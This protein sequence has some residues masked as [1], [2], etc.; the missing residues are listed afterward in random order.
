MSLSKFPEQ[1]DLFE[2]KINATSQDDENGD[3][4]MAED[5]NELQDAIVA[6]EKTLG[7]NPQGAYRTLG[8][9]LST[10]GVTAMRVP[11]VL[12]Y[13]GKAS[14]INGATSIKDAVDDFIRYDH[15]VLGNGAEDP[16]NLFHEITK[17]IMDNV[18]ES[19]SVNFYGYID[20]GV[21]TANLTLSQIQVKINQW[22][23]MGVIGIFCDKF[24]FENQVGRARQNLILDSIHQYGLVAMVGGDNPDQLFSDTMDPTYNPNWTAPNIVEGDIYYY[25]KFVL[26]TT[27]SNAYLNVGTMLSKIEKLH[28]YRERLGIKI[29]ATS[30]IST[31]TLQSAAQGYYDYAHA[32]AMLASFDGFGAVT[33]DNSSLTNAANSYQSL[34]LVG[35]WYSK[36]PEIYYNNDYSILSRNTAFGKITIG[37]TSHNYTIEGLTVPTTYLLPVANSVDATFLK[38]ASIEDIKIKN[39]NGARLIQAINNSTEYISIDR[40]AGLTDQQGNI[41]EGLLQANILQALNAQIGSLNAAQAAIGILTAGEIVTGKLS[42][43]RISASVVAAV[44]LYAATM[45]VGDATIN[46]AAIG[47]L[48]ANHIKAA[49]IEAIN[50]SAENISA[51]KLSATVIEAV[52]ISAKDIAADRMRANVVSAINLYADQMTANSAKIN[53]ATIGELTADHIKA[54]VIEAINLS[55]DNAVINAARI[56]DLTADHIKAVVVEA[57]N[58]NATNA[59]ID[60]AKIGDL[61][62]DNMIANVIE[63]INLSVQTATIDGARIRDLNA[64]YITAG[65]VKAD[66]MTA[67]VVDAIN[68]KAGVITSGAAII[69]A[70]AIGTLNA[71]HMQAAVISAINAS[72]ESVTINASRIGVL[73]ADNIKAGSISA[74]KIAANAVTAEKILAGAVEA[75]KIAANAVTAEKILAGA[76]IADKIATGAIEADKIAADAVTADKIKAGAIETEHLGA[77]VVTA[78][79]IKAGTITGT[80]I[81]ADSISTRE[82]AVDAVEAENIKAGVITGDKIVADTITTRELA[83]SSVEAENIKAGAVTADAL[84]ANSVIAGKIAANAISADLIKGVVVEAVNLSASFIQGTRIQARTIDA[85]R[86][87]AQSITATEIAAGTI[88]ATNI[89]ANAITA[90]KIQAGTITSEHITTGGLDAEIISVYNPTTGEVLIGGGYLRVDGLDVGVVQ[91]DNLLVNGLFL[92]ASS[93]YGLWR[94]N[95][96]GEVILGAQSEAVGGHQIWKIDTATGAKLSAVAVPGKKPFG[97]AYDANE[98]YAYV[99]VQGDNTIVQLDTVNNVITTNSLS[100]TTAPGKIVYTG[101]GLTDHKHFF[102]MGTDPDDVNIPDPLI[103]VDA[104]PS[105]INS[106]LYVHHVI[107]LGNNPYDMALDTDHTVYV[108]MANQ[109]DIL[110]LSMHEYNSMNWKVI[111]RIPIS[112]YGTDNYHGGLTG[113]FGLNFVVGGNASESYV[114]ASA[115]ASG[116]VHNHGGYGPPEGAMKTYEPRG[117]ALSTDPSTLYV[118]DNK[119]NQLVI[120]DKHGKAYYNP[121]TGTREQGNLGEWGTPLPGL[122]PGQGSGTDT[123]SGGGHEGHTMSMQSEDT[124]SMMTLPTPAGPLPPEAMDPTP[125]ISG[126]R[127]YTNTNGETPYVRYRIDIGDS[128]EFVVT[129]GGKIFVTLSGSNQ[130]AIMDE[131]EIIAKIEADR[132]YY[133]NEFMPFPEAPMFNV[134]Y[135]NVGSK[136]M[137]MTLDATN[138]KLYVALTAQNQIAVL[139]TATEV[140][141]QTIQAGANPRGMALTEDGST[142]LVANYGGSGTLSFV[143]GQGPYI[144]DAYIGLEGQIN[145]HG[146]HGWMP[147]RSDWTHDANGNVKSS[148]TIEFRINEPFLNEGGYVRMSAQG[149]D[150][151]WGKIEQDIINVINYS[152][153]TNPA[154]T[155]F[156]FHNGSAQI[157]IANGSSPNFFTKFEIDEFVPKF[158]IFDIRQTTPF[159]PVEDGVNEEYSGLEYSVITNRAKGA[160]ITSSVAPTTGSLSSIVDDIEPA[161]NM[162]ELHEHM[163]SMHTYGETVVFPSGLQSVRI[164][165][166]DVY[167]V[168]KIVVQ[169]DFHQKTIFNGTKTEVSVDGTNWITVYDSAIS[170]TYREYMEYTMD[171]MTEN[172]IDYGKH[173]TFPAIPVRYVRDWANGYKQYDDNW[174]NPVSYTQ[175]HWTD[176]KVYGDW[177][178]VYGEVYPD[179]TDRAGQPLATNGECYISTDV[180]GAWVAHD[181]QIE[182]TSWSWMTYIAGPEFGTL[183]VEMPSLMSATHF[184]DQNWPY[185]TNVGHRHIMTLSPSINVPADASKD[186]KAGKHRMVFKQSTGRVTLDKLR[187]DDFQYHSKSSTLIPN[188]TGA[189]FR[190]FK[191]VAEQAKSYQGIGRQSTEGAYDEVRVSPD[192]GLPDKSVPI[193]YRIRVKSELLANGTVEERGIAYVTSC[194]V[195]TGKLSTHWRMSQSG[196]LFPGTRIETWDPSQPHKTG[197][198][199]THLANGSVQGSKIMPGAI[200]NHHVSPYARIAEWKL[201]LAY[202]THGHGRMITTIPGLPGTWIDNKDILDSI[203]GWAA[204]GCADCDCGTTGTCTCTGNCGCMNLGTKNTLARGDHNHD[205]R[206]PR[207]KGTPSTGTI[208]IYDG[209]LGYSMWGLLGW[210]NIGDK[211]TVFPPE[212]HSHTVGQISDLAD[213]YYNKAQVDA[214]VE[215]GG[216]SG[217]GGGDVFTVN[218]NVMSGTNTFNK[219]GLA[220]KIQPSASVVGSTILTQ[221][222]DFAGTN[223]FSVKYDGSLAGNGSLTMGGNITAGSMNTGVLTATG[224]VTA[225]GFSTTGSTSTGTLTTTGLLTLG[226]QATGTTHAV[227]ADRSIT[228]GS[229]LTGGGNLTA[230]RSFAVNFGGT[231]TATTVSRS[232]H[233]H[234]NYLST[235]TDQTVGKNFTITG[236]L[237]LGPVTAD[238][239]ASAGEIYFRNASGTALGRITTT[240]DTNTGGYKFFINGNGN[241]EFGGTVKI[242]T[243]QVTDT[244][245]VANL[246]AWKLNG[247][248]DTDFARAISTKDLSGY[249]VD[250]GLDVVAQTIPNMTVKITAGVAYTSSGRRFAFAGTDNIPLQQA[251][252]NYDRLDVIYIQ[253]PS[254]GAQEGVPTVATGT[255]AASP[256]QPSVPADAIKLAVVRVRQNAGTITDGTSSSYDAID[257]IRM[258]RDVRF[259]S[260]RLQVQGYLRATKSAGKVTIPVGSTSVVWT[261]NYGDTSY[262]VSVIS[263]SPSRHVFYKNLTANTIEIAVDEAYTSAIDVLVT[264][265]GY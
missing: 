82:L 126:V 14:S 222:L 51:E 119:N 31:A 156:R 218:D 43:D 264:L 227:R 81:Q 246:N 6:I 29:F 2:T 66:Y 249:G 191:I 95:Q 141:I 225:A 250:N 127:D 203:E 114:N 195:E 37:T 137:E 173:I 178:V 112:A 179:H 83:A 58:L 168:G 45:Q 140:V 233:T 97:V 136:P 25:N 99:T 213:N 202:P 38:D 196:D 121:L 234:S 133:Y 198:Q 132:N 76:V 109:G 73:E 139:D 219:P 87:K 98:R 62:V 247:F 235:G 146:A 93:A 159:T 170:G 263:N 164:D 42:A 206:Y 33:Q 30:V 176:I 186:I 239:Y 9:R 154:G 69:E 211:P 241:G 216:G 108:T 41:S 215:N 182:F 188:T 36:N 214:L 106:A 245:V 10:L 22:M 63:A 94:N 124:M 86:I 49:V 84:A 190:R 255:A 251:S 52:N 252:A 185:K 129:H 103:I 110:V 262:A 183:S 174:A 18:K 238:A 224:T 193:K 67:N 162:A 223:L 8:E 59:L 85:D 171:G 116:H 180:S 24:G 40:I 151:Q 32:F 226:A 130:I 231:G 53:V 20:C 177:E 74:D 100:T 16:A 152:D 221:V 135:V 166:G 7:V 236:A 150:Y 65:Q 220:I 111:G 78:A 248:A 181:I 242:N 131:A 125:K 48:T 145:N 34:G 122:L 217:G 88:T 75:D 184:V 46:S 258:Y 4:V 91:S 160:T 47:T 105:S 107:P 70:G 15:I 44:N 192:T 265:V 149:T 254:A 172:M 212:V 207:T 101:K 17:E 237:Y 142:L 92:T 134:R 148:A 259:T 89:A 209:T 147:D 54:K 261:H 27:Q 35:N 79:N 26:D 194:V 230:D 55:T 57:I 77:E 253:G 189:T 60:S 80:Q 72:F 102:V 208:P 61:T 163:H 71:S 155:L 115:S 123:S 187:Y 157:A 56:Q 3:Y 158:V 260:S 64:D 153:G 117:I 232:D 161:D 200:M 257:D 229:G 28:I 205:H 12:V 23:N 13:L 104:G 113:E 39:Y 144:G 201:D 197:I 243:L 11:P 210:A 68:I 169:H 50:I 21:N 143:Y 96:A 118:A 199:S 90:D 165:L 120:V 240:T 1:I 128:P 167:M 5:V 175:N 244:G 256:V 138:G 19:K 204:C 228:A